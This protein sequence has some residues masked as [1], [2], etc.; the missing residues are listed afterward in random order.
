MWRGIFIALLASSF[1]CGLVDWA[2]RPDDRAS[3]R[4]EVP[5][6]FPPQNRVDLVTVRADW[7]RAA[8][9]ASADFFTNAP[10]PADAGEPEK[11]LSARESYEIVVWTDHP[12]LDGG[13]E[14]AGVLPAPGPGRAMDLLFV[15]I[16]LR[17][18]VCDLGESP[19]LDIGATYAVDTR[20]WRIVGW[21]P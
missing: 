18:D 15:T 6:P 10:L 8:E 11:C 7:M 14:D 5:I 2:R 17:P 9:L 12:R 3:R 4:R 20:T 13:Q 19:P 1:A 21:S 16:G